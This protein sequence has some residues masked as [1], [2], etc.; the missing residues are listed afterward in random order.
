MSAVQPIFFHVLLELAQVVFTLLERL[1]DPV[2][3]AIPYAV[4]KAHEIVA[5]IGIVGVDQN[6]AIRKRLAHGAHR[7]DIAF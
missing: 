6:P 3:I 2:E 7:L 4:Q 5:G 1:L